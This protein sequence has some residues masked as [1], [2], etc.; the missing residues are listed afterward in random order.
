MCVA[1]Q[2]VPKPAKTLTSATC[3]A[4]I[5]VRIFPL[6]LNGKVDLRD[7]CID[8][9]YSYEIPIALQEDKTTTRQHAH[10]PMLYNNSTIYHF[11]NHA[12]PQQV[13]RGI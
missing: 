5:Y 12:T 10:A 6:F 4:Q 9:R 7:H 2:L 3:Q 8:T 11:V 1:W 13:A